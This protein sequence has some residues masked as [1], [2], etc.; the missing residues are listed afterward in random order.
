MQRLQNANLIILHI[1]TVTLTAISVL[2]SLSSNNV[3]RRPKLHRD[4]H[5]AHH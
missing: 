3:S 2:L 1:V 4:S 5:L